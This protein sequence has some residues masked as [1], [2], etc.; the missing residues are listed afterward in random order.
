M[1]VTATGV[2]EEVGMKM[3]ELWR[4]Y[5]KNTVEEGTEINVVFILEPEHGRD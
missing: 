1:K 2:T 5:L 3:F 4:E